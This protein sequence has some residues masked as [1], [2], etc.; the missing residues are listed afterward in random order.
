[1]QNRVTE[2]LRRL[3][4]RFG[5]GVGEREV[6]HAYLHLTGTELRHV[7]L[8][9]FF[10]GEIWWADRSALG[11]RRPHGEGSSHIP[12]LVTRRESR[13]HEPVELAPSARRAPSEIGELCFR[14]MEPPGGLERETWFLLPYRRPVSRQWIDR[15]MGKLAGRDVRDLAAALAYLRGQV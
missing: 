5:E 11:D 15:H 9:T 6:D 4:E 13:P 8:R 12:A 7:P 3:R 14:A 1:M 2:R 10:L